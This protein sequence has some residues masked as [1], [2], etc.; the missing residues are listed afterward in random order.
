[1]TLHPIKQIRDIIK[2]AQQHENQTQQLSQLL[3]AHLEVLHQ[4]IE[5]PV[6]RPLDALHQFVE[7]Y[8]EHAPEFLEAIEDISQQAGIY[9]QVSPLLRVAEEYFITPPKQ[10][11]GH[12]GLDALLD[13]A[14]LAHRLMEELNDRFL[15]RCG[16]P[17]VPMNMTRANLIAHHL[18]GEPF[19]NELDL[20]VEAAATHLNALDEAFGSIA[21]NEYIYKHQRF[22]WQELDEWPCLA[23]DLD[24][25][26][27]TSPKVA[28]ILH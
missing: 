1:M 13:E 11:D 7:C 27:M 21:F 4:A 19:A 17:L 8:I 18:I 14:Y 10:L 2:L 6:D 22:G 3:C 15:H 25:G 26:L 24:I 5:L 20:A 12:V 28:R 9:P 23:S 16:I